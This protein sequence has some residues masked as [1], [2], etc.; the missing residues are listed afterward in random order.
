MTSRHRVV[1]VRQRAGAGG[2]CCGGGMSFEEHDHRPAAGRDAAA[3]VRMEQ[4]GELYRAVRAALPDVDVQV[5]EPRNTAWLVPAI[6]RDARRRGLAPREALEQV[7]RGVADGA[8]VV[9]GLVVSAGDVPGP[10]EA[11][12]LVRAALR[13]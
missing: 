8:M 4:V 9:D 2:G 12:G 11:L 5:V 13:E 6:W 3:R 1:L 10:A 7:R